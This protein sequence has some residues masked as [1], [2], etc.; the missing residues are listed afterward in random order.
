VLRLPPEQWR[1]NAWA[2][3]AAGFGHYFVHAFSFPFLPLFV[4]SV[5]APE[6]EVAFWAGAAYTISPLLNGLVGPL[7]ARLSERFGPRRMLQ[8]SLLIAG[9]ASALT[10]LAASPEQ[11]VLARAV[12]GIFGG[13]TVASIVALTQ[14]TPREQ[15]ARTM[16]SFQMSQTIGAIVGPLVGGVL[17]DTFGL[18]VAF[19]ASGLGFAP[20]LLLAGALY[21]DIPAVPAE[22]APAEAAS[23]WAGVGAVVASGVPIFLAGLYVLNFAD[24]GLNPVMPLYLAALGAPPESLATAAGAV[25]AAAS[26]GAA[27]SAYALGRIGGR[28]GARP[29]LVVVLVGGAIL[30]LLLAQAPTWWLLGAGRV[31][32]GLVVGGG[33]ALAYA[34][35][36]V[37]VPDARRALAMGFMTTGGLLGLA[38]GPVAAGLTERIGPGTIFLLNAGLY[39]LAAVG[40]L[41]A[42]R[43]GRP[44][45][46]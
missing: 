32:L 9:L 46:S 21:R 12:V 20:V 35:A 13:F 31:A 40:L 30:S 5:G 38:S 27:L 42:G 6:D 19:L 8:R 10:G 43:L 39:A 29:V 41:A 44:R 34:A 36:A 37:A 11:I 45:G 14:S 28:F 25:V 1:R 22:D 16:G 3:W 18:R 4:A 17:A 15:L 23:R 33:P 24:A 2:M 7:W 26:V